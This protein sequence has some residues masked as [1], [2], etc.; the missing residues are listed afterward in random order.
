MCLIA[1]AWQVHPRY[2]L[3]VVANRDEFFERPT[4]PAHWWPDHSSLFAGRDLEGGGTWLGVTREGR[5][6]A[7]TNF[8]DPTQNSPD[9]RSRG[10]L[11][12]NALTADDEQSWLGRL[13]A[14]AAAYNPFNL[15]V[16]NLDQLFVFESTRL[17]LRPV[18]PGIHGLSN[19]LFNTPWPKLEQ[20]RKALADA[21]DGIETPADLLQLL[22]DDTPAPDDD[23]PV[24]GV[25]LEWERR[26]SSCFIRA[27]GYGTRSSSVVMFDRN[28]QC[29]FAEQTWDPDG[30]P[31]GR[32]FERFSLSGAS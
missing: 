10:E 3:I 15:L 4:D 30:T 17:K 18:P 12:V 21:I 1:L 24:T 28:A 31:S 13:E 9:R 5:F 11:V 2:P 22:N 6:A 7:L 19:H 27:P 26:L 25:P 29:E 32:V 23:L 14:T 20:A 16:G 8:R